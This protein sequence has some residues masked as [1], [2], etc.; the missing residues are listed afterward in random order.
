MPTLTARR[1]GS[2][3]GGAA[4]RTG[5]KRM[6]LHGLAGNSLNPEW[7]DWYMG[8]PKNWTLLDESPPSEIPASRSAP[9]LSEES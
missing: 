1:Y 3:R 7:C 5:K 9:K 8:A 2:N 4:G 6:S